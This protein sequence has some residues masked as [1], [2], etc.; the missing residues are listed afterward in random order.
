MYKACIIFVSDKVYTGEE[1]DYT[2]KDIANYLKKNKFDISVYTILPQVKDIFDRFLVKCC[3]EYKVDIVL[4]IG[5]EELSNTVIDEVSEMCIRDRVRNVSDFGAFV[6]IGVHQDGLVH[7][8]QMA[9]RFVRHPLDIVKV[10]DVIKV[11]ILEVDEKRKRIS[12]SMKD[13]KE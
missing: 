5:A 6:D 11:R 7:K 2:G 8:S 13:I 3:D 12:L 1:E 10:G 9:D 4:V